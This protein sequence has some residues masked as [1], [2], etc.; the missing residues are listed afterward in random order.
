DL[1]LKLLQHLHL[2]VLGIQDGMATGA[3][4]VDRIPKRAD[5]HS[6]AAVR[7]IQRAGADD[8]RRSYGSAFFRHLPSLKSADVCQAQIIEIDGFSQVEHRR[9]ITVVE[10]GEIAR[11]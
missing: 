9:L 1:G 7:A 6:S 10:S 11:L 2:R 8:R 3:D 4:N 5:S